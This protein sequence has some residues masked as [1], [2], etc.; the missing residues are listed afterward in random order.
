MAS[1]AAVLVLAGAVVLGARLRDA[2][3]AEGPSG[4]R[5]PGS[6][7]RSGPPGRRALAALGA[8]FSV[9]LLALAGVQPLARD[10]SSSLHHRAGDQLRA[11]HA[12][13]AF[14]PSAAHTTQPLLVPALQSMDFSSSRVLVDP[15]LLAPENWVLYLGFLLSVFGVAA[16]ARSRLADLPLP[17]RFA[18]R[19][20]ARSRHD[21][22]AERPSA[23]DLLRGGGP[24]SCVRCG[25]PRPGCWWRR[26]RRSSAAA[27]GRSS[28]RGLLT[29]L[30]AACLTAGGALALAGERGRP[31]A[32][33]GGGG[34]LCL[35]DPVPALGAA[36][37]PQ[38]SAL[39]LHAAVGAT[40]EGRRRDE[41][42]ARLPPLARR[43]TRRARHRGCARPARR[44]TEPGRREARVRHDRARR[45]R[46][47]FEVGR[48]PPGTRLAAAGLLG[49][50]RRR[51]DRT[52]LGARRRSW[53]RRCCGGSL[54][55]RR[56]PA[57]EPDTAGAPTGRGSAAGARM[58]AGGQGTSG[59]PI[60][61]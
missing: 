52:V 37:S 20:P 43:G 60:S 56:M 18:L 61:Q 38:D 7:V 30:F 26:G 12:G 28:R 14:D 24:F 3:A 39:A 31:R 48:L 41:T 19:D 4:A 59:R 11:E 33:H 22:R 8:V 2:A 6:P 9:L 10:G 45:P 27:C 35:G 55:A 34:G 40:D 51:G 53:S 23:R 58:P 36:P 25:R 13:L 5:P 42:P 46:P 1:R 16:R 49:P 57:A 50:R 17:L 54:T 32:T 44:G 47:R 15:A 29:Q 21:L